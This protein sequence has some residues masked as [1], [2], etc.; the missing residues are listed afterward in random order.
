MSQFDEGEI[1]SVHVFDVSR[2]ASICLV[3]FTG[4][5]KVRT[6]CL[7]AGRRN[8][9]IVIKQKCTLLCTFWVNSLK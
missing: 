1:F 4:A 7:S 6:H 9:D 5:Q 3:I 8:C 2:Q